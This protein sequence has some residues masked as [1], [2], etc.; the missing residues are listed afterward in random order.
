[1]QPTATAG[2][3]GEIAA[4]LPRLI[5]IVSGGKSEHFGFSKHPI[6]FKLGRV[7]TLIIVQSGRV[8]TVDE[9]VARKGP[10]FTRHPQILS[11]C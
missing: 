4:E 7:I 1:M 10:G 8:C 11:I 6:L 2:R 5:F 9:N 3:K